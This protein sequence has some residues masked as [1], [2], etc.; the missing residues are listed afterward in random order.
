MCI[1]LSVLTYI[2]DVDPDGGALHRVD[3]LLI[4][5]VLAEHLARNHVVQDHLQQSSNQLINRNAAIN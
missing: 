2:I 1:E 4:L 3:Q 5:Q